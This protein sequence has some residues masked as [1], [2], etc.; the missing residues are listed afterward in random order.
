MRALQGLNSLL[1]LC[2]PCK[3]KRACCLVRGWCR[4]FPFPSPPALLDLNPQLHLTC[5]QSRPRDELPL[6]A[7]Q[8]SVVHDLTAK[9]RHDR[10][11]LVVRCP[12][13]IPV[14]IK[15]LVLFSPTL[16]PLVEEC[17]PH[18]QPGRLAPYARNQ[19]LLSA[20]NS[21]TTVRSKWLGTASTNRS[22]SNARLAH[23]TALFASRIAA[24][25]VDPYVEAKC[26]Q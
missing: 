22:S 7:F 18:K 25:T 11:Q 5:G 8:L 20:D 10:L 24:A 14:R 21:N 2:H 19:I 1:A 3:D 23:S 4:R 17:R 15:E 12:Y 13:V 16:V 26:R 6:L 9:G